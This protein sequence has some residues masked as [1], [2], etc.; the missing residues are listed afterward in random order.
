MKPQ[1][2]VVN[3]HGPKNNVMMLGSFMH[4]DKMHFPTHGD[5]CVRQQRG[6]HKDFSM[7]PPMLS[8][9][10]WLRGLLQGNQCQLGLN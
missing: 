9:G 7:H 3:G 10:P 8:V 2:R 5:N 1:E 4:L 6:L